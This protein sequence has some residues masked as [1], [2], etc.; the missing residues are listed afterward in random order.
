MIELRI[1]IATE[2]VDRDFWIHVAVRDKRF[3]N[4]SRRLTRTLRDFR[5]PERDF[6]SR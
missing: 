5:K 6:G 1:I 3:W 2:A 4:S